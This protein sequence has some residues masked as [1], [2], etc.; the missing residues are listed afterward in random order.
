MFVYVA[1]ANYLDKRLLSVPDNL[2]T[3]KRLNKMAILIN[4]VNHK[5]VT[6]AAAVTATVTATVMATVMVTDM[7]MEEKAKNQKIK[8]GSFGAKIIIKPICWI[9]GILLIIQ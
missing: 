6:V 2:N 9:H 8:N 7:V 3:E 1:R 5:E 4:G